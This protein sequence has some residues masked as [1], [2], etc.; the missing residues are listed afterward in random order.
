MTLN[1]ALA[2]A[3]ESSADTAQQPYSAEWWQRR[4][5]EE[6]RD[7]INR[8]FA[9]GEAFQGAVSE[10]ER[11]AREETRRLRDLAAV[12]TERAI[13][14]KRLVMGSIAL[15]AIAASAGFIVGG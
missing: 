10:A 9:G 13:K 7:I 12:A 2:T 8:G 4:T 1:Q 3:G 5:A 15:V 6:L 14:R 11:R